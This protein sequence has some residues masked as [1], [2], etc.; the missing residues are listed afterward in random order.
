MEP[1]ILIDGYSIL[2]RAFYGV[3]DRASSEG[4]HT[5]A[6]YGF[7][8][9]MLQVMDERK[10][11]S[12]TAVFSPEEECLAE[13]PAQQLPLIKELLHAMGIPVH[14]CCLEGALHDCR[15][16]G[17]QTIVLTGNRD[18]LFLGE[19]GTELL[20]LVIK[21][22]QEQLVTY[23]RE[24]IKELYGLEPIRLPETK[25]LI[26]KAGLGEKRALSLL[27]TWGSLEDL[28]A[29]ADELLP[30]SVGRSIA[31]NRER[32]RLEAGEKAEP[33]PQISFISGKAIFT[34]EAAKLMKKLSL[35][36]FLPRFGSV[37][38]G[39]I[40]LEK[41]S[42]ITDEE[43]AAAVWK[44]AMAASVAGLQ[45]I[46]GT[47]TYGELEAADLQAE[48]WELGGSWETAG[49]EDADGQFT[50][51]FD[52]EPAQKTE[53][54]AQVLHRLA[55]LALCLG[56]DEVYCFKTGIS[57]KEETLRS[58]A[59]RFLRESTGE[60]WF[61]DLKAS[62]PYLNFEERDGICD[63]GVAA[64][65]LNPLKEA[66]TYESLAAD[67]LEQQLPTRQELLGKADLGDALV[68]GEKKAEECICHMARTAFLCAPVLKTRLQEAGMLSLY[69]T[70]EMPLIYSLYRMEREGVRVEREALK[71]YGSRLETGIARLEAEIYQD[72]GRTFNINSP[73]QLGEILFGEMN[74]PGG[75]KT[76]TGYSTAADVLEK[77]AP[78]HP[79]VQKILDYRQLTKL[80][81]TYAQGLAAYIGEDGRIHGKFNQTITATGRISSTEPNLQNIP[82]RMELGREIRKVFVPKEGCVFIDAD[83]SQIELRILAHMSGDERLIEAYR[84]AQDIHAITAS[85]VFH[86]PLE[87]VTPLQ[88]RSAKAVNFGIVYGISAFGLSEGLSV[89]RKEA[90]EYIDKYFET[91][92]GVKT[93]LD[94]LVAQGKEEGYVSTLYG[95]RRPIPELASSSFNQRQFGERVAMNSP[96]QGT[97]ADIMKIAMIQVD[98]ELRKR[99]LKSRIVLQIHDEL[100]IETAREEISEVKALLT[101]KMKHA[102]D[103]KVALEVEA[104]EGTSWFDAK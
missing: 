102:A 7:F 73:K 52:S 65:L 101:D 41:S 14:E 30:A 84:E 59:E 31:E 3:P 69:Q 68:Q 17:L 24:K 29:H 6:V 11:S 44:K 39:E 53:Q 5:N 21:E 13:G 38:G 54:P 61:M 99:G 104:Q 103:L 83:Y 63:A 28:L 91:Y 82:V 90:M 89:S 88:R 46:Q 9:L 37:G 64:Y 16:R 60:I 67:Y 48:G 62:L 35:T 42:L 98:R 55:G 27:R 51:A 43:Q 75:K 32:L 15:S 4:V 50:F 78:E 20:L 71:E 33:G 26:E 1:I 12:L 34:E 95:R 36:S 94:G 86:V 87:E 76:K 40:G 97:A 93:F 74:L 22:G 25:L 80:N 23:S 19:K 10:E 81:S 100:L 85:Q 45:L 66:Y 2:N 79:V 72:T 47:G 70:I 96:I 58:Q 56:K 8:S 18:C 57:L 77:L 49:N 92:P